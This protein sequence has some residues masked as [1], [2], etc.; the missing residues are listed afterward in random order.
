MSQEFKEDNYLLCSEYSSHPIDSD[1]FS[2]FKHSNGQYYFSFC[3]KDGSVL[4]RSEGY[5]SSDVR[6]NGVQSVLSNW[7]QESQYEAKQ[8]V[9]GR[10]F[11]CLK[12]KN[13]K[14]IARSCPANTE[15][16]ALSLLNSE[17]FK[18]NSDSL[19]LVTPPPLVVM[20]QRKE[21]EDNY[22]H[23]REYLGHPLVD[24]INRVAYFRYA[25]EYYFAIYKEDGSV[26]LRSEGFESIE[27]RDTELAIALNHLNHEDRYTI[28]RT[29]EMYIKILKDASGREVGRSCLEREHQS[30]KRVDQSSATSIAVNVDNLNRDKEDD[31]L[32]C[33]HYVGHAISDKQNKVAFFQHNG[34]YYFVIYYTDG[35]VRLR[36]E[37]FLSTKDRDSE[38]SAALRYLDVK[39]QYQVL[40]KGDYELH[41]LKD[42]TGREVGRSCLEKVYLS[43]LQPNDLLNKT[44]ESNKSKN[45]KF[46]S[47]K[48]DSQFSWWWIVLIIIPLIW[49]L[50]RGCGN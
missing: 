38:L 40:R 32:E 13:H 31:Y 17:R 14:E 39:E 34:Q 45:E 41:I 2:R 28:L 35:R 3:G 36:S 16:E 12:A 33:K 19:N 24:K 21:A 10:W 20:R 50:M 27:K 49:F 47:E 23:C 5:S 42:K 8:L 6:E 44:V 7:A 9:D 18:S 30:D 1:G 11:L 43:K 37:G 15:Q 48:T 4:L 22:L 46:E 25:G 29:G 26:Q